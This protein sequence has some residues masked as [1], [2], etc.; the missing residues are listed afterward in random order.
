MPTPVIQVACGDSHSLALTKGG[1]V[2]SWGLNSHGQLGAGKAVSMQYE[3][4]LVCA[5]NGIPVTH[6]SAGAAHTLFLTLSGLVYC[7]GANKHGQLGVNR[8]DEKGRFNICVIPALRCLSVSFI[9]CGENHSAVLTEEGKVY[10]FGEG[11]HG[12][13]GHSSSADEWMPKL[14]AGIDECALQ[15]A[16]GRRHT[17]VLGSSGQLWAFGNGVKGQIGTGKPE[18]SQNPTLVQLPWSSDNATAT[19][20]DLKIAAGWNTSFAFTSPQGAKQRQIT[21]R[22]D[23]AK[24][25]KW[26]ALKK[27]RPEAEREIT[28]MFFSSSS[29]V[30]SF[31]KATGLSR[32][33]DALSVDLDAA[34]QTFSKMLAVPW[35][36]KKVDFKAVMG[37]LIV[38]RKV[39]KSPEIV[40][41]LLSCP[42]FQDVSEVLSL[43]LPLAVVIDDMSE[44]CQTTLSG[45]WASLSPTMLL[46]HI[47][48]FKNALAFV[49]KNGLLKTH[50]PGIKAA[51]EVIKLLY[52][53]N[54]RGKTYK[55]PLST[56]Y[57]DEITFPL[58]VEDTALWFAFDNVEDGYNTPVIFCRY[59]FLLSLH[60][61]QM[62]FEIVGAV[63]KGP[64]AR[65]IP[66]Y[67]AQYHNPAPVFQLSLRPSH[68]LEDTF[69][70]LSAVD[71]SLFRR[72]LQVQFMDDGE[73]TNVNMSD[74]F[75]HIFDELMA[76][77]SNLFIYNERRTLA[78]FPPKPK[79]AEKMYFLFG[80]LCGLALSNQ[81]MVYLP[82]PLIFFKKL[83]G[84][85]P[86]L[87]DLKEF[88]PT[89]GESLRC[90]LE[91]YSADVLNDMATTFTVTWAD[92]KVELDPEE[93]EKLVTGSNKKAFVAAF[94]DYV[95]DKSEKGVFE[96][97]K[98]GF[99]KVC[100]ADVV[101]LFQPEELQAAM[102][103][104][105]N[106]D[107]DV[108][109]QNTV[110][111]G[112]YHAE[113][114]NIITFWEVFDQLTAEE[115]RK[116]LL[117]LTGCDRV[118]ADGMASIRMRVAVLPN[119]TD[120]HFP[121][122][123]TCHYLLLL[124]VYLRYPA[125][126]QMYS[127]LLYAIN[128]NRGFTKTWNAEG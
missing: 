85:K 16:C 5:L 31:T 19:R 3:P 126:R 10:T 32:E 54:K 18:G 99:L 119:S 51:L 113:H 64:G 30:A 66:K 123:V 107:W 60:R 91:D 128:Y 53:A 47:L 44:R 25:R 98:R 100:D 39:L 117:F 86:S 29:L 50:F 22:L 81:N 125:G 104:N 108:F 97:F 115:K 48:V 36:Q 24:L 9:T 112:E 83:L 69:R 49:I 114:L 77:Q 65:V 90:I 26:L 61:K 92:D 23:E 105:E 28:A 42:L 4:L 67:A 73:V 70:Q 84:V 102:V 87:D 40:V 37:I 96:V 118:P 20:K 75:F 106:Y 62:V 93:P 14:V 103:G 21:G 1:D 17:L 124:P 46:T 63:M 95:F 109:K 122:A 82:F 80:V 79:E 58:L 41:V 13:L 101:A 7:C 57:V 127:R 78:W 11:A 8:A 38:S 121:E 59:P 45:W 94:V 55:V 72:Q 89:V 116:F 74:L 6:I 33:A 52:K 110:Y 88:E 2:F 15:V 76:P 12:Q 71:H 56:F 35:I 111:E 68:L 43:V 120:L 27:C 34:S